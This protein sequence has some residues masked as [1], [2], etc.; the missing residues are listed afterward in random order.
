MPSPLHDATDTSTPMLSAHNDDTGL[1][2]DALNT[3][4]IVALR[5][6]RHLLTT[7]HPELTQD[8]RFHEYFVRSC[9]LGN[10]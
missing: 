7:F 5:Q 9:V 4:A 1:Q 8:N 10:E 2:S 6:G 3:Q